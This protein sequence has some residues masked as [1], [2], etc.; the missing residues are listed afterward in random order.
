LSLAYLKHQFEIDWAL[1]G[2]T[3]IRMASEKSYDAIL[4]DINLGP[5][6]DGLQ[7]TQQIRKQKENEKTP[8]IALTGYTLFGDRDRLIAG[9]CTEY[10]AKPFTKAAI[11]KLL[12]GLFN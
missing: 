4:M 11:L 6:M 10:L 1:D 7:A 2:P 12:N 3:A 5:G 9:G 8:I